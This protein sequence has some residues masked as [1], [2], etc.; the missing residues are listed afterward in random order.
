M[1][2]LLLPRF[3]FCVLQSGLVLGA[4][5]VTVPRVNALPSSPLADHQ[6]VKIAAKENQSINFGLLKQALSTF[7]QATVFQVKSSLTIQAQ[8]EN[9][10]LEVKSQNTTL[11]VLPRR[12]VSE[13]HLGSQ[14]YFITSDGIKVWIY[15]RNNDEYTEMGFDEFQ[16]SDDSFLIGLSSS[17]LLEIVRS[18]QPDQ[19]TTPIDQPK[20]LE[21][22]LAF[23]TEDY[24]Q[25][26]LE[27]TQT[28]ISVENQDYSL[29]HYKNKSGDLELVLWINTQTETMTKLQIIGRDQGTQV[30]IQENIIQQTFNPTVDENSFRFRPSPALKKVETLPLEP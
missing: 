20:L 17:F 13:I 18:L 11:T 5:A 30:D 12:F 25:E 10:K 23:F 27:L 8:S 19:I 28:N 24:R 15:H 7:F 16:D 22:I 14:Q 2:R 6:S 4:I 9:Q 21:A 29:Y 3:W 26:D 1:L